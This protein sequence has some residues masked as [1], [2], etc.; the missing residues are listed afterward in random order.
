MFEIPEKE[1]AAG[2]PEELKDI[3]Y[4]KVLAS[5]KEAGLHEKLDDK[6]IDRM[7]LLERESNFNEDSRKIERG[8]DNVLD[9]LE[10]IYAEQYPQ[11][12]LSKEQRADARAAAILH[13]IGKSG[14]ATADLEEQKIIVKIFA[15]ERKHEEESLVAGAFP[16]IFG[17]EQTEEIWQSLEKCG[18]DRQSTFRQFWDQHAQ[19]THDILEKY[20][21]GLNQRTRIIAGSHH[22]DHR[23]NPYN[24]KESEIP[25]TANVIGTLEDY[26]DALEGRVLIAMDQ[27]EASLRRSHMPH[28]EAF[29][30]VCKNL[31][32]SKKFEKDELMKLVLKVIDKLGKENKIFEKKI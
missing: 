1:T 11:L 28:E 21:Q 17:T 15:D 3:H 16:E 5:L 25:L 22:I 26:A 29:V 23:I 32:K 20:P 12:C 4:Q 8:T 10:E 27:Y 9:S 19:W 14:P 13:D 7:I 2:K 30:W 31:A 18:L 24:L 6:I